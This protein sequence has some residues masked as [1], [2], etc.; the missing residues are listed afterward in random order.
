MGKFIQR[1]KNGKISTWG[2]KSDNNTVLPEEIFEHFVKLEE[3]MAEWD[4]QEFGR[5][6][7]TK[8]FFER[9]KYLESHGRKEEAEALKKEDRRK[10]ELPLKRWRESRNKQEKK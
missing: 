10:S 5:W 8:E 9:I 7:D 6:H 1:P 2:D 4:I 3:R